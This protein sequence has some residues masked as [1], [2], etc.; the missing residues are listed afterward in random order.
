VVDKATAITLL[1]LVN[2]V[3]ERRIASQK[4]IKE[5]FDSLPQTTLDAIAKRDQGSP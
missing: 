2:L 1:R 5:M 4:R 3:V